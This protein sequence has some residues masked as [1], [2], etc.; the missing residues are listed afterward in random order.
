MSLASNLGPRLR[1]LRTAFTRRFIWPDL[2]AMV[3]A[4]GFEL[5]EIR[6][7]VHPL[8]F[9]APLF[10]AVGP[11]PDY[12]RT[13]GPAEKFQLAGSHAW[14]SEPSVSEFLGDLAFLQRARVVVELGCYVGW[15]SAHLALGL[16]ASGGRLWCLDY[17]ARFLAAAQNN[18]MER[19]LADQA[20]FIKGMS[21]DPQVLAALPAKIDLLFIDTSHEYEDTIR[22]IAAY[23]PRLAPGG[24]IALHDSLSQNG[25]RRAVLDV[26]DRFETLTFATE[27]GNGV[28]VLKPRHR[29]ARA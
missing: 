24:M 26:W 28:T 2:T 12:A 8:R 25:V 29:P 14:N 3:K 18:L 23:E 16:K 15:T 22:E 19:G 20:N 4:H 13:L 17:D 6:A 9:A 10:G 11:G 7:N 21:L 5:R 27:F 1:L